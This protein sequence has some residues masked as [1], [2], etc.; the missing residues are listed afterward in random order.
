MTA[1][2]TVE[3]SSLSTLVDE[4]K[5]SKEELPELSM[6]GGEQLAFMTAG[7]L[8]WNDCHRGPD[9]KMWIEKGK[10]EVRK[11]E[12]C[13]AI[14][15]IDKG[16]LHQLR[17]EQKKFELINTYALQQEKFD[18]VSKTCVRKVRIVADGSRQKYLDITSTYSLTP[19]AQTITLI[20]SEEARNGRPLWHADFSRAFLYSEKGNP[21]VVHVLR[22]PPGVVNDGVFWVAKHVVYGFR[23]APCA[24][25]NTIKLLFKSYCLTQ[26]P[27]K[28]CLW[29][30]KDGEEDV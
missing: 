6:L 23:E 1:S 3:V 28:Q 15:K 20:V 18:P 29:F 22:P 19:G 10:E 27:S 16:D 13:G 24:F 5:E 17:N 4:K 26:V 21:D 9:S 11:F 14:W 30:G 25:H 2:S 8:T 7:S 12:D